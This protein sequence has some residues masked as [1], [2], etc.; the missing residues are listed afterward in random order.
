MAR[1]FNFKS[2]T[3][4]FTSSSSSC[5][6]AISTYYYAKYKR[7]CVFVHAIY[8]T[9][10]MQLPS[11][12]E[13]PGSSAKKLSHHKKT[14][15]HRSRRLLSPSI[16]THPQSEGWW[17]KCMSGVAAPVGGWRKWNNTI[18][19]ICLRLV[20]IL[21]VLTWNRDTFSTC[22]NSYLGI[23]FLH[24]AVLTSRHPRRTYSCT[25]RR[26]MKER[27][28]WRYNSTTLAC[29]SWR[30]HNTALYFVYKD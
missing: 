3:L 25:Y 20:A 17:L 23:K 4:S 10:F 2:T 6:R 14:F 16:L 19:H 15:L 28:A 7:G 5:M 21:C 1:D 22:A 24:F 12:Q 29:T 27:R 13:F 8:N 26:M 18:S 9:S 30:N 11:R